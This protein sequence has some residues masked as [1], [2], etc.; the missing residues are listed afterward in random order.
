M[1]KKVLFVFS[2]ALALLL[3]YAAAQPSTF[4]VERRAL[5]QAPPER[6]WAELVDLQR[7]RAWSPWEQ[8]DPQMKR[9]YSTPAAGRGAT[10]AWEGNQQVGQ[11]RMAIVEASAPARLVIKL[12]FIQPF[13]AH[14]TTEFTLMP[15]GNGTQ[16]TWA[17]HGPNTFFGKLMQVFVDMDHMV[18][19]DFE[20]G[21][22]R[23]K[24]VVER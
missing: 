2:A 16:V 17:M 15:Q 4:R 10:Y 24:A 19:R 9:S 14:N 3:L 18:G 8:M 23:L 7:W 12:D 1:L 11:G 20:A 6:V 21:L 13:E 5:V 22:A